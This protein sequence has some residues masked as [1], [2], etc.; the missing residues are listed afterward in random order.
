MGT[1]KRTGEAIVLASG[2][3]ANVTMWATIILLFL[4][5]VMVL[6]AEWRGKRQ[7]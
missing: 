3:F 5:I 4:F 2:T 7:E 1:D 6:V